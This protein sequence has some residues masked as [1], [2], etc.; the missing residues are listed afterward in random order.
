MAM[1]PATVRP[2]STMALTRAI[3]IRV[4]L[5]RSD[6]AQA[7]ADKRERGSLLPEGCGLWAIRQRE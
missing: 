4:W 2:I 5:F 7:S 3:V 6:N 1:R